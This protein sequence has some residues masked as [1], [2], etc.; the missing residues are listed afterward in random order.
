MSTFKVGERVSLGRFTGTVITARGRIRVRIDGSARIG[1]PDHW[2][3]GIGPA[4]DAC[5]VCGRRFR[6]EIGE[7]HGQCATCWAESE[8][9]VFVAP[10]ASAR[11]TEAIAGVP[12]GVHV[13]GELSPCN[14]L[15][16]QFCARC[17]CLLK[18]VQTGSKLYQVGALIEVGRGYRTILIAPDAV[19]TCQ[20]KSAAEVA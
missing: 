3:L 13:A 19:P 1:F 7:G 5:E 20:S 8:P 9:P 12:V 10:T 18:R 11:P 15:T 17:G 4:E 16:S 2:T 6:Y 14:G